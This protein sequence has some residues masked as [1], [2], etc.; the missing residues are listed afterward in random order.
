MRILTTI[1]S[2]W[3]CFS[4]SPAIWAQDIIPIPQQTKFSSGK[5][6]AGK[7]TKLYTNLQGNEKKTMLKYFRESF[8]HLGKGKVTDKANI[9]RLIISNDQKDSKQDEG[10]TLTVDTSQI[11]IKATGGAG[12]FYG[13]QSLS[14]L[15]QEKSETGFSVP[16]TSITDFPRFPYRGIMIDVSRHFFPKEYIFKQID[17]M[18]HFKLNRLHLHLTDAG[19]WRIEIKKYPKLTEETSYRTESDWTKWWINKDRQYSRKDVPGAYGGYFTQKDIKEIVAYAA[20]HHITVI[21]EIEIPGHS[22]EVLF[23]FPELSCSGKPYI[24]SDFCIG[25]EKSF[26]FIENV[27]KEIIDLFPSE[28]IHIGGDEAEQAAW[29]TCPLCQQRMKDE[30]LHS[31]SELQSYM[32][33][34]IEKFLNSHGRKLL[35]WDE[36]TEGKLA[37]N[38]TVMSW[39]GTSGG[40]K[41]AAAGHHVIMTPGNYCYLDHAQDAPSTQPASIGGYLPLDKVYSYNPL[42]DSLQCTS[43]SHYIDGVQ[44][45]LWTEYVTTAEHADYMLYPRAL[46][47]AE[48]G[49]SPQEKRNF[50]EFKERTLKAVAKLQ[51]Q[52]YHPFNLANEV[53]H[54]KESLIP[55]NHEAKGKKVIY[56]EP[57][58]P[59]YKAQGVTTLTDGKRGD[60]EYGDGA[61]QGFINSKRL[62]VTVDMETITSLND[63]SAEFMQAVGPEV[64][65]PS[66]IILSISD[67]NQNFKIIDKQTFNVNKAIDYFIKNYHWEGQAKAR[68][69]K[70][71]AHSNPQIGGWIFTDEIIVN[72]KTD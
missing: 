14:Q 6:K 3:L 42:P 2:A 15:M 19:G 38:A 7:K 43:L 72:K 36:I 47:I 18:A 1:L 52:G 62:D 10:Y 4:I 40:M 25:N 66:E 64:F 71:E 12:L 30:N 28:Y 55:I 23:A 32:I 51:A 65:F 61:W 37:P 60:W 13:L 49:W 29:K 35:G 50:P 5:F 48:I 56:N 63:V 11:E 16:C 53:G 26:E 70:I 9:I 24:N 58:N 31:T 57:Y 68:F 46:A 34:R 67:D 45:N 27:L 20:Q 21:P 17:V 44:G 22:G 54:R 39:R 33:Q 41:A 8:F 69:I 59:N